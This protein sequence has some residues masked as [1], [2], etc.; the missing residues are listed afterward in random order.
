M[1]SP[2]ERKTKIRAGLS[3]IMEKQSFGSIGRVLL[4]ITLNLVLAYTADL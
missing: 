2:V 3:C 1:L 4:N